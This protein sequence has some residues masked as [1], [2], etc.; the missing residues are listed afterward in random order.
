MLL[1]SAMAPDDADFIALLLLLMLL[2][3][4]K[5]FSRFNK[6]DLHLLHSF[7]DLAELTEFLLTSL[8]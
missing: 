8:A 1:Q 5:F 6:Q 3:Q 7:V 2:L 4:R